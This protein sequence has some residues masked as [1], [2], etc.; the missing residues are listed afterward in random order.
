MRL[1]LIL[2]LLD[3]VKKSNDQSLTNEPPLQ[4]GA[5]QEEPSVH[6]GRA[7]R[8]GGDGQP[9]AAAGAGA[10]AGTNCIEMGFP[11]KLILSKRKGLWEVL[12]S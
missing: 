8:A 1:K 3:S 4:E 5:E 7:R 2:L 9:A 11:G 12:F 6:G 10:R